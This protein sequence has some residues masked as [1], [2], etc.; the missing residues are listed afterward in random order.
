MKQAVYMCPR[1]RELKPYDDFYKSHDGSLI[2]P[3]IKCRRERGKQWYQKFVFEKLESA[4]KRKAKKQMIED[5][6]L[7][8]EARTRERMSV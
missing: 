6:I 3:C 4:Q 2:V 8:G 1:C 5:L 7:R